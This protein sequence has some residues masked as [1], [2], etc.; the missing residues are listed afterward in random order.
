VAA[1]TSDVDEKEQKDSI[2]RNI[3]KSAGQKFSEESLELGRL[4]G[5]QRFNKLKEQL[6]ACTKC[7]LCVRACPVCWC[8][9]CILLRKIKTIDPLLLHTTRFV[10][11]GDTCVNCGKCDENCPKGIQL[12]RI[13]YGL[14][15]EL[16]KSTGYRPGLDLDQPSRRSGKIMLGKA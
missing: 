13:Y 7:G 5:T 9:D 15:T 16:G 10:H 4:E 14:A 6:G 12:S 3:E 2:L 11:M 8:K 1:K